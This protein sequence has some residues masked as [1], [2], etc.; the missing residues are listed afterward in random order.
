MRIRLLLIIVALSSVAPG[1]AKKPASKA[2]PREAINNFLEGRLREESHAPK[3]VERPAKPRCFASLSMTIKKSVKLSILICT[4]GV[5]EKKAVS[6][7]I[8][9]G[10]PNV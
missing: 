7:N 10:A 8:I 5:R 3:Q 2:T 1:C 9:K 6:R 4:P